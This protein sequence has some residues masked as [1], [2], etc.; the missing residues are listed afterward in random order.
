MSMQWIIVGYKDF[1][2]LYYNVKANKYNISKS[3][4]FAKNLR[5]WSGK[6]QNLKNHL[7]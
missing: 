3:D 5:L 2:K 1:K 6:L 4:G 7:K